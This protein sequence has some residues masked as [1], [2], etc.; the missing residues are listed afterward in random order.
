MAHISCINRPLT[1]CKQ[2]ENESESESESLKSLGP[3]TTEQR[4]PSS[5]TFLHLLEGDVEALAGRLVLS[6]RQAEHEEV[7]RRRAAGTRVEVA[8]QVHVHPVLGAVL[9]GSEGHPVHANLYN[10]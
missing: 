6:V 1:L 4:R 3:Q 8:Q 2:S 10:E 9:P 7:L 5:L